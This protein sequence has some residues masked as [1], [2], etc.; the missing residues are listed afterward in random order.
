MG[1]KPGQR[2]EA[3]LE[4]LVAHIADHREQLSSDL[5]GNLLFLI[6]LLYGFEVLRIRECAEDQPD[7]AAMLDENRKCL[8]GV[9]DRRSGEKADGTVI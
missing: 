8:G 5:L 9:A 7:L 6:A 4:Q 2:V 1:D 3:V